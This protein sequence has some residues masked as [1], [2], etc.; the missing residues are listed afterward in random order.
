MT[1]LQAIVLLAFNQPTIVAA[2]E[3]VMEVSDGTSDTSTGCQL[4]ATELCDIINMDAQ[5][6]SQVLDSLTTEA[7]PLLKIITKGGDAEGNVLY[8]VN[9]EFR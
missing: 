5:I 3:H 2:V 1:V 9:D 7:F 6:L 4:T 8:M